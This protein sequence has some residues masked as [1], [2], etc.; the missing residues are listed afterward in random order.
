M[1]IVYPCSVI[2]LRFLQH[3]LQ[4]HYS[5]TTHQ[6]NTLLFFFYSEKLF[7]LYAAVAGFNIKWVKPTFKDFRQTCLL[8]HSFWLY[9]SVFR[10]VMHM[11]CVGAKKSS[12]LP[13]NLYVAFPVGS[14]SLPPL[15]FSLSLSLAGSSK[16]IVLTSS[17]GLRSGALGQ[18]QCV[19]VYL[20]V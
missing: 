12:L 17:A 4:R 11:L 10:S 3:L 5:Y 18:P 14:L 6:Q 7:Q 15:P 20:R 2:E 13:C 19:C 1:R 8:G 16:V 9:N